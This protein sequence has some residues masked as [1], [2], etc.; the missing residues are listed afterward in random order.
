MIFQFDRYALHTNLKQVQCDQETIP[1]TP[2]V[3]QLLLVL[4]E[5][6][7]RTM[8]KDELLETLWPDTNV[9]EANLAQNI[10][11]LRRALGG[12]D[13]ESASSSLCRARATGSW[14]QLQRTMKYQRI[15][16]I[17]PMNRTH[18]YQRESP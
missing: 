8:S 16:R 5:N 13:T 18:M 6:R 3:F 9:E 17:P 7:H 12:R 15:F 2:K 4:I 14:S 11:V 1:L 10:S